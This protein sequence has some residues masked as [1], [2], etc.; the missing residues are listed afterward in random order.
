MSPGS[1][2]VASCA[3]DTPPSPRSAWTVGCSFLPLLKSYIKVCFALICSPGLG[4]LLWTFG[5]FEYLQSLFTS[6]LPT[7][8]PDVRPTSGSYPWSW[9]RH[10]GSGDVFAS[11]TATPHLPSP[12]KA[13]VGQ[14]SWGRGLARRPGVGE[15]LMGHLPTVAP[16]HPVLPS[17]LSFLGRAP[18]CRACLK[19]PACSEHLAASH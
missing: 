19:S 12:P 18:S 6:S 14:W 16:V 1:T 4:S 11:G 10:P 9:P 13:C 5:L 15:T 8:G 7:A 3:S 2:A 17:F